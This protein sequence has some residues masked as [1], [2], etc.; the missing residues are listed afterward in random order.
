ML[1]TEGLHLV[2]HQ[3]CAARLGQ[4]VQHDDRR[5]DTEKEG[6]QRSRHSRS[7][8]PTEVRI[9]GD[10]DDSGD[11]DADRCQAEDL[12]HHQYQTGE[13]DHDDAEQSA[14]QEDE[15]RHT[16]NRILE[17]RADELGKRVAGR[18]LL[19][20]FQGERHHDDHG[21]TVRHDEPD[22]SRGAP[23]VGLRGRQHD[24]H[25]P[26]PHRDER[27]DTESEAEQPARYHEVVGG[28]DGALHRKGDE[29]QHDARTEQQRISQNA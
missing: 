22:Q 28:L 16:A 4:R 18:H 14:D 9:R 27:R 13:V 5:P 6:V 3:F 12:I 23:G 8:Q 19:A 2:E 20:K 11:D 17:A 26:G 25:R 15:R 10:H 7:R 29:Q 1:V 21:E 24:G